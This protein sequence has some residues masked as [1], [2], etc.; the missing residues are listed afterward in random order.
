MTCRA[1]PCKVH[2]PACVAAEPITWEASRRYNRAMNT[3]REKFRLT[4]LAKSGG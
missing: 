1:D 2:R 4:A 3:P